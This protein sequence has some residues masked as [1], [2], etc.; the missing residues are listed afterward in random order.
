M[1]SHLL[2]IM[3]TGYCNCS[4]QLCQLFLLMWWKIQIVNKYNIIPCKLRLILNHVWALQL[5]IIH[6]RIYKHMVNLLQE[7]YPIDKLQVPSSTHFYEITG[8]QSWGSR[9]IYFKHIL[10]SN[11][12]N[13]FLIGLS[14]FACKRTT[15]QWDFNINLTQNLKRNNRDKSD[16][17]SM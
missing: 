16:T 7:W 12:Y 3:I 5:W 11:I 15:E 13:D 17:F 4:S 8:R 6:F 2:S 1:S 9:S 14:L 10:I